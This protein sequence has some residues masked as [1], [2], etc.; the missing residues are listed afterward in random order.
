MVSSV[1]FK[2]EDPLQK[3]N[4]QP[5]L[6]LKQIEYKRETKMYEWDCEKY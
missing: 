4:K 6:G 5:S 2:K 3:K 1:D